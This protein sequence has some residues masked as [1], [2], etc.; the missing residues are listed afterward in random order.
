MTRG[1][2]PCHIKP[3]KRTVPLSYFSD[4]AGEED[5]AVPAGYHEHEG[6][7]KDK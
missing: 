5:G 2:S 4:D 3:D 7:V 6:A 1:L